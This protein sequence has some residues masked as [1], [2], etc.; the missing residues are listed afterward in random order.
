MRSHPGP[1][2]TLIVELDGM[3][4]SW[5]LRPTAERVRVVQH[6]GDVPGYHSGF[7]LVPSRGFAL[8]VLTNAEGGTKLLNEL[9]AD[10]WALRRF[11][12]LRNLPA[13][14]H[15]RTRREL[16]PYE[17]RYT[18]Q[19]LD[20]TGELTPKELE[21]RADQG[22]LRVSKDGHVVFRLAFYRHDHVLQLG[23]DGT[24]TGIRADFIRGGDGR[25]MWLRIGGRLCRHG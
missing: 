9:F 1:G 20:P 8:T 21:L 5:M 11:A 24:P 15:R 6:G 14:P 2:G 4:V 7:M 22:G 13:T 3:G 19:E 12:G 25:I 18:A 16:A 17:G 10:D 23:S